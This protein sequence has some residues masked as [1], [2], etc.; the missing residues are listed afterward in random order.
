MSNRIM[1]CFVEEKPTEA[2][3]EVDDTPSNVDTG[4][5]KQKCFY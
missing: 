1:L 5:G 2:V 3:M 4:D